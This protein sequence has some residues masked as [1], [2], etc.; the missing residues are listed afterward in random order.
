VVERGVVNQPPGGLDGSNDLLVS[1]LHVPVSITCHVTYTC[2]IALTRHD[3]QQPTGPAAA[4]AA[5][6]LQQLPS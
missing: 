3:C 1:V 6:R 2:I 5:V 4:V